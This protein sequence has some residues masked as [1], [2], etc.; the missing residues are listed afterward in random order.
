VLLVLQPDY[1]IRSLDVQCEPIGLP[2]VL[3]Y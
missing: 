2:A 1:T 3:Y